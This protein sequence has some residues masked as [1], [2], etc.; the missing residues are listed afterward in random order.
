MAGSAPPAPAAPQ[1]TDSESWRLGRSA[2]LLAI[3]DQHFESLLR[4]NPLDA[5][6]RGDRRFN[7]LLPDNSPAATER[8]RQEAAARLAR[9]ESLIASEGHAWGEADRVDADLLAYQLRIELDGARFHPEQMPINQRSGPQVWLPQL[10]DSLAFESADDLSDYAARL[11]AMPAAI[12]QEIEQMRLGMAAGR[13]PPRV[14]V[15]GTDDQASLLGD[16]EV[17]ASPALSPFFKPFRA[18]PADHPHARR[19]ATAIREGIVPAYRRLADFLREQYIPA[20]RETLGIGEGVDGPAAYD[21]ALRRYTT[22][23][24]GAAQIHEIG[25]NE[26]A[27]LRAQ[28]MKVIARTDWPQR[29]SFTGDERFD[30][31][32]DFLRTDRRFYFDRAEDLLAGYRDIAKK[33]DAAL[34]RLF[35]MLPRTPYGVR[36][37]PAFAAPTSPTA[38]YFR[39]SWQLGV[40]GFFIANTYRLDQR[41]KYEMVALTLHEACPGHHLQIAISQELTGVHP[42]REMNEST[43]FVEGWALYAE[44]LG[45][46]IASDGSGERIPGPA[47]SDGPGTGLYADPYDDFGRLT[48]EMWRACRL[49]VDT[50]L[51][52]MGWSR[53]RAIDY[54]LRNTALSPYNIE[55]EVDRYIAWPGQACAYKIGQIRISRLR[56]RAEEALGERFNIRAFHDCVLGAG[57]VPLPV[58]EQR[59]ERW[60]EHQSVD[61]ADPAKP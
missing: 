3:L 44:R 21:H 47:G 49:V 19:A 8:Q 5:T 55:R 17:A 20:C 25:V 46:E 50:G 40:P 59:V 36:E 27:R 32:V 54:M 33:V 53:Q 34:P 7:R 16:P 35:G 14:V 38:Y 11:E 24:L 57:A 28:M 56:A 48:Y 61:A 41:P 22:T 15:V 52:A 10:A 31:F 29:D 51:H 30:R 13:V 58:L 2:A 9:L 26:V 60:L 18:L 6:R 12:D 45:L 37:L 42:F 39:G 4:R 23:D 43:A 1:A